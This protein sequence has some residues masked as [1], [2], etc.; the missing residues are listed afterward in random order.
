MYLARSP[1]KGAADPN[2]PSGASTAAPYFGARRSL[3]LV[4]FCSLEILNRN[5]RVWN[6]QGLSVAI[7]CYLEQSKAN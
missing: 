1:P 6:Y 7:W 2:A 4:A 3:Q 5:S